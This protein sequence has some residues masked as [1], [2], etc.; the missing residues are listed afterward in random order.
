ML[1]FGEKSATFRHRLKSLSTDSVAMTTDFKCALLDL[2][3]R[4]AIPIP[5]DIRAAAAE[6][7]TA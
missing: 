5:D 3:K 2:T 4:E 7:T 1:K 6:L